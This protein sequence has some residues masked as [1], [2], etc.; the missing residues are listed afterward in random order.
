MKRLL[1]ILIFVGLPL[2]QIFAQVDINISEEKVVIE[3]QKYYLHTV[4][5]SQTLFSICKAYGISE[6]DVIQANSDLTGSGIK[7]GQVLKIPIFE[8]IASDGSHVLYVVKPGDTLYSLCRKYG[9]TEDEFYL[10][11]SNLKR[12]RPLKIG[13]E[14]K[15]PAKV[16]EDKISGHDKDTMKF[17][18]H[19]ISKGETVYSLTKKYNVTR[20][21]LVELNP[22]FDGVK[23]MVGEVL[24]IPRKE[25]IVLTE[26]QQFIDSLAN[27]NFKTDSVNIV[28]DNL[29][30]TVEWYKNGKKFVVAVLLPFETGAN[31]RNLYNQASSNRE[32]R[33]YSLTEKIVSF[34]SGCL[35]ALE[36]FKTKDVSIELKVFDIGKDNTMLAKI[37]EENILNEVNLIIGPAFRSQIDFINSNLKNEN[38][39]YLLPFVDDAEILEKYERAIML[40]PSSMDIVGS[41]ADYAALNPQHNYL[42][43][44][45][46]AADQIKYAAQIKE[47]LEQKLGAS[48]NVETIKFNGKDLVSLKSMIHKDRENVFILPFNT[49]TAVTN[50]FLDL[51]PLKDYEITLI[52]DQTILDYQTIDPQYYSKVKF[53]YLTSI[54]PQ[55]SDPKNISFV[56]DYRDVFLCEPDEYSFMAYDATSYFITKLIRHG[57]SFAECL[58]ENECYS[59]LSGHW[60]FGSSNNYGKNSFSNKTVLI[61]TLQEDYSFKQVFPIFSE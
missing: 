18:Y 2:V 39:V 6:S 47:S 30:D 37:L 42:I 54:N 32:Q 28:S 24:I 15:F 25:G 9:V 46:N 16:I 31:M 60:V 57:A 26:K 7:I 17:F 11:N 3:G 51:F 19:L 10:I 52:G 12:N 59:G 48:E 13:D 44:Q 8:E 23:L 49:E 4:E 43:I 33:L 38:V 1:I 14:I 45:G 22:E 53:S 34:Y 55:Y 5:K 50:I 61:F 58:N 35:M 56:S 36:Q 21:E 41:L 29:C 20:E 27:V 40:K